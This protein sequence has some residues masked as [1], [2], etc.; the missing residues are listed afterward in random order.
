MRL[1]TPAGRPCSAG[2]SRPELTV[3]TL[4]DLPHRTSV[5]GGKR[6]SYEPQLDSSAKYPASRGAPADRERNPKSLS[7]SHRTSPKRP[8]SGVPWGTLTD[9]PAR[10][11]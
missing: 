8:S 5:L 2:S 9:T 3:R 1:P 11:G 10:R 7:V 6:Q 4:E